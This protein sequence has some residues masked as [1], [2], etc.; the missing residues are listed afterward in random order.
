MYLLQHIAAFCISLLM[1]AAPVS[2]PSA[3]TGYS[4]DKTGF[5]MGGLVW[6]QRYHQYS[7]MGWAPVTPS[8]ERSGGAGVN[9]HSYRELTPKGILLDVV[10]RPYDETIRYV[11]A[12]I[13]IPEEASEATEAL[14]AICV[15]VTPCLRASA[16][17]LSIEDAES[18]ACL[19]RGA[20]EKNEAAVLE[21]CGLQFIAQTARFHPVDMQDA[22]TLLITPAPNR[23]IK[24]GRP[25]F[26]GWQTGLRLLLSSRGS[27]I[28]GWNE[29]PVTSHSANG[30]HRELFPV[31]MTGYTRDYPRTHATVAAFTDTIEPYPIKRTLVSWS[32]TGDW[33]QVEIELEN[34]LAL[35]GDMVTLADAS[36]AGAQTRSL[37]ASTRKAFTALREGA[38]P[39]DEMQMDLALPGSDVRFYFRSGTKYE[40]EKINILCTLRTEYGE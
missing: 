34:Y 29:I 18:F 2:G 23:D 3:P 33:A 20:F 38:E 39:W 27:A 26:S 15:A 36:L 25:A 11:E 7:V 37:F 35:C 6:T 24:G 21:A 9:T 16:P 40:G 31:L 5:A 22:Y 10:T 13:K 8:F 4:G 14:E 28:S 30:E 32:A 19:A 17:S 1:I 12:S